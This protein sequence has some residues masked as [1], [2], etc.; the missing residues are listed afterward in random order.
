LQSEKIFL[1][2]LSQALN[3]ITYVERDHLKCTFK[4]ALIQL[5]LKNCHG[6]FVNPDWFSNVPSSLDSLYNENNFFIQQFRLVLVFELL[7]WSQPF[8]KEQIFI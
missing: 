2:Q 3:H 4:I 5:T 1:F 6:T 7:K 8:K